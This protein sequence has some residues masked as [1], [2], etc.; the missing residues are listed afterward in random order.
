[1]KYKL[2]LKEKLLLTLYVIVKLIALSPYV[3]LPSVLC[4]NRK[5]RKAT[6]RAQILKMAFRAGE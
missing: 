6:I 3:S 1:M 2:N 4:G 5:M